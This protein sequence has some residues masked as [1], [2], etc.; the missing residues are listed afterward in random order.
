MSAR[1][2][3]ECM[4]SMTNARGDIVSRSGE[5]LASASMFYLFAPLWMIESYVCMEV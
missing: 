4:A 2:S 5:S 1:V 3:T